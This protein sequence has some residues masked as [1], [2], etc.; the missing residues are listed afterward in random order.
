MEHTPYPS[1][2]QFRNAVRAVSL[3]ARYV[4]RDENDGPIYDS[5]KPLPTLKYVGTVKSHGTNLAIGWN[6]NTSELWFQSRTNIIT[7][8]N[9]NA[10]AARF[11]TEFKHELISYLDNIPGSEVI[12]FMEWIGKGIQKGVAINELSKRAILFD[13][14]CDGKWLSKERVASIPNDRELCIYNIYNFPTYE[15]AIDFNFPEDVQ[16]K[17]VELTTS[18]ADEC[19][20]AKS[21]GVSGIGEGIVWKCVTE[22]YTDPKFYF[23]VKDERHANSKVT[24]LNPVDDEKINKLRELAAIVTPAW[25]LSQM[26]TESCDLNNGGAIDRSKMGNYLKLVNNDICK[27]EMDV[28]N[29]NKT[30][31]KEIVKYVGEI[32]RNYFFEQEKC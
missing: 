7:P 17:L 11:F 31:F 30:D 9:D 10:G 28:L 6:S 4:G 1:I 14:L 13:V 32:A 27:E 20:I 3:T 22:G 12:V 29:E 24:K 2:E 21:F 16:N 15:F 8:E 25:R 26:L 19:P 5:T 18:V 23:K